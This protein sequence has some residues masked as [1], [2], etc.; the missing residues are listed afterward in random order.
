MWPELGVCQTPVLPAPWCP[1]ELSVFYRAFV[2]YLVN[3]MKGLGSS[4]KRPAPKTD[5]C[6]SLAAQFEQLQASFVPGLAR[7]FAGSGPFGFVPGLGL[8][9]KRCSSSSAASNGN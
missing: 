8:N 3:A 5:K 9:G 1:V 7:G 4:S 2:I 6:E